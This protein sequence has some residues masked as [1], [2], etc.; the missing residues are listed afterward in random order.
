MSANVGRI[1]GALLLGGFAAGFSPGAAAPAGGA[2]VM[3]DGKPTGLIKEPPAWQPVEKLIPPRTLERLKHA[4]EAAAR[5]LNS[6]GITGVQDAFVTRQLLSGWHAADTDSQGL[7]LRVVA[8]LGV[9]PEAGGDGLPDRQTLALD[10]I[11]AVRKANGM[12]GPRHQIAHITFIAPADMP[13]FAK[14]NVVV[15][16]SPMLWFPHAYTPLFEQ[17]AGHARTL[18]SYPIGGLIRAGALV[19]GGS[20][21]PAGQQTPDPWLGIEGL[22]TR[23]NPAGNVPGVLDAR[24][25]IPLGQALRLYTLNSATAMG[26]GRETGSIEVGKSAD[27]A[28]LSQDLFKIPPPRIHRTTVR[29]TY[30]QGRPVYRATDR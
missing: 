27:F 9:E 24:E 14:L 30:F 22:V 8:S 17:M 20:D 4:A 15:D 26:L 16:V 12:N 21:W 7:P 25:A 18:H 29:V 19:A 3:A 28:V 2:Y 13:R 1:W 10:A 5:T 11:E 23:R 6:F